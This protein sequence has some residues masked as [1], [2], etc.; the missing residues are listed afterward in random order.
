VLDDGLRAMHR[1]D[2]M[3]ILLG[4]LLVLGVWLNTHVGG[5]FRAARGA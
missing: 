4:P 1:S 2:L 3:L 5:S